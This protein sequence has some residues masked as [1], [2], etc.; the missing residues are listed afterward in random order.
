MEIKSPLKTLKNIYWSNL[1]IFSFKCFK[2]WALFN[3][4]FLAA[5]YV[6]SKEYSGVFLSLSAVITLY[7]IAKIIYKYSWTWE[8]Y[9]R[10][11]FSDRERFNDISD[12]RQ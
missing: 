10:I 9:C 4:V 11:A 6:L 5:Y 1:R 2:K 8:Y 7:Y 12:K 3:I